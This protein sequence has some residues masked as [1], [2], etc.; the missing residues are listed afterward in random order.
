MPAEGNRA[1]FADGLALK[2]PHSGEGLVRSSR[3]PR[4]LRVSMRDGGL[5]IGGVCGMSDPNGR[6]TNLALVPVIIVLHF[7]V[8]TNSGGSKLRVSIR[9][10]V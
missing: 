7:G 1:D 3:F 2:P 8:G 10:V 5:S 9:R 4:G 6:V